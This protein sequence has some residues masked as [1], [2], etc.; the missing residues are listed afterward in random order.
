[1]NSRLL[2]ALCLMLALSFSGF[3]AEGEADAP[4]ATAAMNRDLTAVRALLAK[5]VDVNATGSDGTTALEWVV[6]IDD[7]DTAKLLI[8]AGA[9]VKKA[10]RL[11]VT[12]IALAS[13]NGNAAMISLLLGAGV[14]ANAM[15]PNNEP[16]SWAAIRSGNVEALR[17]LLDRGAQVEFKDTAQQTTLMLAVR[18]NQPDMVRL[19]ISRGADVNAVTR[20]GATPNWVRPNSV[21]GFGFGKGIIRG[22]LPA[23]RGSRYLTPGGLTPLHYASRDGRLEV[24]RILVANGANIEKRDPNDITPLLMAISNNQMELAKFLIERGADVN[25]VDWY[26]RSPIWQAVEVRNMDVDN[27]T[28]KNG[29]DREPVLEVIKILL[30]KGANPNVRTAE[31]PPIRRF[32]LPTTGT[33][34]WVDFVGMTPFI[35]AARAGDVTVMKMLLQHGANPKIPTF[36]GT[37]ALMAAAGMNWT[38]AQTYD[39]GTEQLLEAVKLTYDLGLSVNDVNSMGLTALHAAANRPGSDPIIQWL[40]DHGAKMDVKD[41][42]GRTPMTWAEGVFLATHPGVPKPSAMALLKKLMDE[43]K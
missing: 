22:G 8:A 23:D 38:F 24:A 17:V 20:T 2:A 29:V 30:E 1:M 32:I 3:A 33:L 10:N 12:P 41:K 43:K 25:V 21:A 4:L 15:D 39:E 40:V 28:F 35:F 5:K 11:G 7:V 27:S 9:D 6:R 34:E 14:D 36:E 16:A 37:T 26:G 31:S 42:E 13:A 19:L 18:E